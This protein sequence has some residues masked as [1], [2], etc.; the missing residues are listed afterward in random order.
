MATSTITAV[1]RTETLSNLQ[2]SEYD[3]AGNL[4]FS[5]IESGRGDGATRVDV[6]PPAK[7]KALWRKGLDVF[8]PDGYPH[9]VTEDY[10]EYQTYDSLQ[11]VAG[12]MAGIISSRAVWEGI[13]VGDA[14]ASPTGAML[15]TVVR[16][17]MGKLATITFA[18]TMGTSIEPECK[19]YR[20]A[21]DVFCDVAQILDCTT[22]LL[23]REIRSLVLCISSILFAAAGVAGGSSKSSLSAHFARWNNLGE[24]NAKDSS[25][26]TVISLVGMM[27]GT[28]LVS[29]LS[30]PLATWTTLL[31]LIAIHLFINRLG[32]R[33]VKMRTLNRQRATV[34]FS[35]LL[36]HD[37][38]LSPRDVSKREYIFEPQKKG[39][40]VQ[41]SGAVVGHCS[42]GVSLKPLLECLATSQDRRPTGSV[43][44]G[45]VDL[46]VLLTLFRR[47]WYML[48]YRQIQPRWYEQHASPRAE[49]FVS[50]KD[51]ATS[52]A[53][54]QAWYHAQLLAW[55]LANHDGT[56]DAQDVLLSNVAS[57]LEHTRAHFPMQAKRLRAVGWDLS[58]P[59]LETHSGSR[60]KGATESVSVPIQIR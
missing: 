51:G 43:S 45:A 58:V 40:L 34:L 22:P 29:W 37:K 3:K 31:S 27:L 16:E 46:S 23:P 15:I 49:I 35:N 24:V 19:F 28:L 32:V 56:A 1:K 21:S 44:L 55:V 48:W 39:S 38:V 5:Y 30:T 14:S 7:R 4:R 53:Q 17:C 9:S 2:V 10:T 20:L 60:I 6:L 8:L 59:C 42:I 25:Q 18:H 41:T 47:E 57:T 11:A 36:E 12:T 54:L 50:L 13:G 33:A 52:E 26:E